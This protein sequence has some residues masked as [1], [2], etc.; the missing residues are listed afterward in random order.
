[1]SSKKEENRKY[2]DR[3]RAAN[4]QRVSLFLKPYEKAI[5]KKVIELNARDKC[6][7]ALER[8]ANNL[9]KNTANAEGQGVNHEAN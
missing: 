7:P 5:I 6:F 1:M 8:M 2:I 3:K 4:L 9:E